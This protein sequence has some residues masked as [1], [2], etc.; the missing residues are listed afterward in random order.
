MEYT[1]SSSHILKRKES[2]MA[3]GDTK[4]VCTINWEGSGYY[5]IKGTEIFLISKRNQTDA[6]N[7]AKLMDLDEKK[8]GY[9]GTKPPSNE[10][11]IVNE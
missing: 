1:A 6:Q 7:L 9:L 10:W 8:V 5:A 11:L 2:D 4:D 3:K